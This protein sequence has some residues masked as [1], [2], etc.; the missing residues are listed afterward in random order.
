M[1]VLHAFLFAS[2]GI[3]RFFRAER[4]GTIEFILAVV[5][6]VAGLFLHIGREDWIH[7]ILCIAAVFAAEMMNTAIEKAC[8]IIQPAHDPRIM[9]IKDM[10]AGS[11]L[12]TALAS[13]I[14]GWLIFTPYLMR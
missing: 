7:V 11:V 5:A 12:L 8:D 13:A 4:N 2:R 3:L 6:V 1:K 10:A 14:I 9:D